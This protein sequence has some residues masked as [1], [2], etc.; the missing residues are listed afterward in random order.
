M[1]KYICNS[2]YVFDVAVVGVDQWDGTAGPT[3]LPELTTSATEDLV[4]WCTTNIQSAEAEN[5]C[6]QEKPC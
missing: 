1:L 6:K 4:S 3:S 2:F 5:K